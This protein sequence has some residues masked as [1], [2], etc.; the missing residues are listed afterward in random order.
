MKEREKPR[1]LLEGFLESKLFLV[2]ILL[3]KMFIAFGADLRTNKANAHV[4]QPTAKIGGHKQ[5]NNF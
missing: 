2:R 5:K 3:L 1:N 4:R